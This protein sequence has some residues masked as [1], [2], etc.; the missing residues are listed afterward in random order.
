MGMADKRVATR[1]QDSST[2]A[3]VELL[4]SI[5][6]EVQ[7]QVQSKAPSPL[8]DNAQEAVDLFAEIGAALTLQPL[9]TMTAQPNQFGVNGGTTRLTWA[10]TDARRVSIEPGVGDVTPVT[11]GSIDVLVVATTTFTA[12]AIGPCGNATA[13]ATVTVQV[14]G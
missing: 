14:L 11:G 4:T 7:K 13:S 6:G 9:P 2:Q 12:T 8:S 3:V 5:L 10:A 1:G